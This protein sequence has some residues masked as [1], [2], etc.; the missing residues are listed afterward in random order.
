MLQFYSIRKLK[1]IITD[2]FATITEDSL[3][4]T[5]REIYYRLDVLRATK[6]GTC[7][8][9]LMCC[10]QTSWVLIWEK[11]CLYCTYSSFLVINIWNQG[12]NLCSPCIY[13]YVYIYVYGDVF[14]SYLS[15]WLLVLRR[16]KKNVWSE[17]LLRT[18]P[19]IQKSCRYQEW[20]LRLFSPLCTQFN[21]PHHMFCLS[22][23]VMSYCKLLNILRVAMLWITQKTK[24]RSPKYLVDIHLGLQIY[25]T[26]KYD[27]TIT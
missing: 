22:Q 10:K 1:V 5:C 14:H 7:W 19:F 24:T 4:N 27:H 12:K 2:A 15:C 8:S 26:H 18:G 16:S 23:T 11:I 21:R 20:R 3:E 6:R 9:V 25:F 13:I 17:M